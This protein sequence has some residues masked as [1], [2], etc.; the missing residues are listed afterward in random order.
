MTMET[1]G[2]RIA[3]LRREKGWTQKQLADRL[4]CHENTVAHW[5]ADRNLPNAIMIIDLSDLFGV[6]CDYLLKGPV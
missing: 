3:R 6:T 1:I 4:E 2:K 5:E